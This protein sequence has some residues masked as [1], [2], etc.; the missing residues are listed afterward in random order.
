MSGPPIENQIISFGWPGTSCVTGTTPNQAHQ[1]MESQRPMSTDDR[2][3]PYWLRAH[4][5]G[6]GLVRVTS[7]WAWWQAPKS[8]HFA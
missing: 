2:P 1:N 7:E 8:S 5:K 3:A 4:A 6:V